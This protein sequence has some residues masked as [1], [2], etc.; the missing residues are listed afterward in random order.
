MEMM[1]HIFKRKILIK[2]AVLLLSILSLSQSREMGENTDDPCLILVTKARLEKPIDIITFA[3]QLLISRQHTVLIENQNLELP[4]WDEVFQV[5]SSSKQV[6]ELRIIGNEGVSLRLKDIFR[7]IEGNKI[8]KLRIGMKGCAEKLTF[9]EILGDKGTLRAFEISDYPHFTQEDIKLLA[10]WLRNN[11]V[12]QHFSLL[13]CGINES[14]AEVLVASLRRNK[15]LSTLSI[16]GD[17]L[18]EYACLMLLKLSK[19]NKALTIR[20]NSENIVL[21]C[22][23]FYLRKS[24]HLAKL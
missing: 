23:D 19:E 9:T 16:L 4:Q 2:S 18:S 13:N 21:R 5:L 12:L 14:Y 17:S 15:R 6:K 3:E 20:I 22:G 8:S 11:P 1:S 10:K 7:I 24:H